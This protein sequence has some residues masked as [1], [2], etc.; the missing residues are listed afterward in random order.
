MGNQSDVLAPRQVGFA[1]L[2]HPSA[3]SGHLFGLFPGVAPDGMGLSQI[4][5]CG[6]WRSARIWAVV[7][8]S[9]PP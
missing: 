2:Q 1:A 9:Y 3:P 8:P 4:T 6:S 7:R 5:Q